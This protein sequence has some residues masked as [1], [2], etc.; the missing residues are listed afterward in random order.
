MIKDK[1]VPINE[2][3][4]LEM[5]MNNPMEEQIRPTFDYEVSDVK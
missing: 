4:L 5:I 3:K 1:L 2:R